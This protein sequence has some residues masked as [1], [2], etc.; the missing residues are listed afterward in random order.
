MPLASVLPAIPGS[1]CHR[2]ASSRPLSLGARAVTILTATRISACCTE[3]FPFRTTSSASSFRLRKLW[4]SSLGG[5][6]ESRANHTAYQDG[7]SAWCA[8]CHGRYH[9]GGATSSTFK[10]PIDRALGSKTRDHYNFYNGDDD[11]T[12]GTTATAYLP[13]VPFEDR[14]VTIGSTSGPGPSARIQCLSCHRAHASSAPS[15]GR[16]DFN[17]TLLSDDGLQSGSYPIPDPYGSASQGPLCHKCHLPIP[18]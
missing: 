2:V 13:E 15:S 3:M 17:V 8:N 12:G 5:G 18:D 16:W 14:T 6:S 4:E 11:P 9:R 7:M 10:H 1:A